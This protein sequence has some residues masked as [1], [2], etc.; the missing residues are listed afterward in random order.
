MSVTVEG[1]DAFLARANAIAGK[2]GTSRVLYFATTDTQARVAERVWDRGQTTDGQNIGYVE[3][4]EVYVYKPPFPQSPSGLGKP[5]AQ[6]KRAKIKGGYEPTYLT[7]K[8]HQGGRDKTPLDLTSAYRKNY[9]GG[10]T[11]NTA[12]YNVAELDGGL[13]CTISLSGVN[14]DKWKGLTNQKGEHLK[15]SPQEREGHVKKLQE[16]WNNVPK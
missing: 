1:V 6:G 9:I 16:L 4:Y 2:V 10:A 13:T 12:P 8:A 7:A 5:N 15:L 3:D 14:V 11:I